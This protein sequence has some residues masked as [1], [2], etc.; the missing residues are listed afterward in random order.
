MFLEKLGEFCGG[1]LFLFFFYP[2]PSSFLD[3][4]D[5]FIYKRVKI[6]CGS[7]YIRHGK[8]AEIDKQAGDNGSG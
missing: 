2:F 6:L 8:R 7:A 1:K 4:I 5:S 3:I